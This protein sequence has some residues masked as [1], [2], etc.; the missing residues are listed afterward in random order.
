VQQSA[1]ERSFQYDTL[2][3]LLTELSPESGPTKY[4]YDANGNL[5]SRTRSAPNQKNPSVTVTTYHQYDEL[6][7]LTTTTYSDGVTPSISRHYDTSLE[8]GLGLDNTIGR[9]SAEY[10][11]SPGGQLLVGKVFSYDPMGNII[12][13]SQCLQQNCSSAT[14]FPLTY[15]YDLLG[16]Q[17]SATNGQGVTFSSTYDGAGRLSTVTSSLSDSAHP[18]TLFSGAAYNAGGSL[19]S[20]LVGNIM[21]KNFAY[22]CRERVVSY[23]SAVFPATATAPSVTTS[24]CP[25][26]VAT[27]MR[28]TP[29]SEPLAAFL[30][31]QLQPQDLFR[32]DPSIW[33]NLGFH[34]GELKTNPAVAT[35]AS[36][37]LIA[38]HSSSILLSRIDKPNRREHGAVTITLTRAQ[39][40]IAPVSINVPYASKD[41]LE[42]IARKFLQRLN[43]K[44]NSFVSA[45]ITRS[46]SQTALELV[47]RNPHDAG[48]LVSASVDSDQTTPSIRVIVVP[49]KESP[50]YLRT[51]VR[52][53]TEGGQ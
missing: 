26:P 36:R 38:S 25:V 5:I 33:K 52:P 47:S 40:H 29:P 11:T 48:F 15:S 53:R 24:G 7:R 49:V 32:T 46:G 19:T 35:P 44:R 14:A 51:A 43:H 34:F 9:V 6:S 10:V 37:R 41:R 31:G 20:V 21:N 4:S 27:G 2:S 42:S 13:N 45:R 28:P 39:G 18:G 30:G 3:R 17:L 16:H 23:G 12:N 50:P 22:D 8:L 1:L